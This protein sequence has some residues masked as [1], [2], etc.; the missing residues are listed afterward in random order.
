MGLWNGHPGADHVGPGVARWRT[1]P[2]EPSAA[3]DCLQ[4]ALRSR[5][6]QQVSASV[7]RQRHKDKNRRTIFNARRRLFLIG[8]HALQDTGGNV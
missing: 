7:R 6:R 1:S 2:A 5:F 3:P 8:R 4:R